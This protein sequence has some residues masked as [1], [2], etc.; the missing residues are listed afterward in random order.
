MNGGSKA[1]QIEDNCLFF[2]LLN[3]GLLGKRGVNVY[4]RNIYSYSVVPYLNS[5]LEYGTIVA[6]FLFRQ[7]WRFFHISYIR[8]PNNF[9]RFGFM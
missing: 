3:F 2:F 5:V 4:Y 9:Y 7:Q 1:S 6:P 8:K